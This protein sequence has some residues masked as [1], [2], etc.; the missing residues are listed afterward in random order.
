ML[1]MRQETG[2]AIIRWG[3]LGVL[4]ILPP[5]HRQETGCHQAT[6]AKQKGCQQQAD[7]DD[8]EG[9]HLISP[10]HATGL[11]QRQLASAVRPT[12]CDL[13]L[14]LG[15]CRRPQ[16]QLQITECE[17]WPVQANWHNMVKFKFADAELRDALIGQ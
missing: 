14:I 3:R 15:M 12:D 11:L 8:Q 13:V 9:F 6:S 1:I 4:G 5:W 10:K 16:L 2:R 17:G 7:T